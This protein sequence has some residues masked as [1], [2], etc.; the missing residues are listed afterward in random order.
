MARKVNFL[1]KQGEVQKRIFKLFVDKK[2]DLFVSFPY[3]S[4]T[5]YY[6]GIGCIPAGTAQYN[7]NPLHEGT[8]SRIPVKLSYHH[9]GHVHFK[10]IDRSTNNLPLS[11]KN[12]QIKCTPF[13]ELK[14]QHIIT[15]EVEGLSRFEDFTPTKPSELYRGFNVPLGARRFKFVFYAG[16]PGDNTKGGFKHCKFINIERPSSPNPLVLGLCFTPFPEPLDKQNPQP[17]LL[18][19]TGFSAEEV[20]LGHDL[21]FLYVM[22]K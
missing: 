8:E 2:G 22:A 9:D 10:P 6:C 4:S 20:A 16:L 18:C 13:L 7:F 3:F 17:S 12:A 11:F 5:Q 14:A 19:L 21:H 1:V 15:V